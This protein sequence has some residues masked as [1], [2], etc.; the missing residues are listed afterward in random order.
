VEVAARHQLLKARGYHPARVLVDRI[1]D[2]QR[3]AEETAE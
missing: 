2:A 1:A 3:A